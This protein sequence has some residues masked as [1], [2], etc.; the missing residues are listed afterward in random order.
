MKNN[1]GKSPIDIALDN[2]SPRNVE[3]LLRK[4]TLFENGKFSS[5]FSDRFNE[6]LNM[7]LKAFNEYL[8]S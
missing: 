4:L 8:N 5:L 6:L 2:E 7:N 3:L 1:E